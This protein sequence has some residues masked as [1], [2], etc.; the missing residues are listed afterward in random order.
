MITTS[1][2]PTTNPIFG[3]S[4]PGSSGKRSSRWKWC[5]W[6]KLVELDSIPRDDRVPAAIQKR[7]GI[8]IGPAVRPRVESRVVRV[9]HDDEV[10]IAPALQEIGRPGALRYRRAVQHRP[11]LCIVGQCP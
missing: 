1:W 5:R 6:A 9:R 7:T 10:E 3:R 8:E 2:S 11:I 4:V